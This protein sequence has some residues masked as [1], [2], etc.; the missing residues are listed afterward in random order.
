MLT[1]TGIRTRV[2]RKTQDILMGLIRIPSTRGEEG[3]AM[4]FL[5]EVISPYVDQCNLVKIDDSIILE[6]P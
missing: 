5:Q 1:N 6:P 3:P 2:K 4:R